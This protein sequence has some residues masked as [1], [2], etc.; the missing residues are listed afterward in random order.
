VTK[1]SYQ[2]M[3]CF[4][5]HFSRSGREKIVLSSKKDKLAKE[6][7]YHTYTWAALLSA[8]KPLSHK[9]A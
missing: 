4:N 5:D 3:V 6:N 7:T 8:N 1:K 2:N 9:I